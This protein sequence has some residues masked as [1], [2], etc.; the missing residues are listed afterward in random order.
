[1]YKYY[2]EE[3][4]SSHEL[5]LKG[6]NTY[7][8]KRPENYKKRFGNSYDTSFFWRAIFRRQCRHRGTSCWRVLTI[9]NGP[10]VSWASTGSWQT[11]GSRPLVSWAGSCSWHTIVSRPLLSWAGSCSWQTRSAN[12]R[13][14]PQFEPFPNLTTKHVKMVYSYLVFVGLNLP[15]GTI[16]E[17]PSR[18]P[19][20]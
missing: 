13:S 5:W 9:V 2:E 11:I 19:R 10:L 16:S 4:N 6:T 3:G 17:F 15:I 20:S 18:H 1:M 8:I 12:K 7:S 14:E